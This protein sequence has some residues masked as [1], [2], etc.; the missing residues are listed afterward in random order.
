MVGCV[1][2]QLKPS[3]LYIFSCKMA[4]A[5][6]LDHFTAKNVEL[7]RLYLTQCI[8]FCFEQAFLNHSN[9]TFLEHLA[10]QR[11]ESICVALRIS[12]QISAQ[13]RYA[14]DQSQ[15]AISAYFTS[16]QILPFG[17]AEKYGR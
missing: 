17:F 16:E 11:A 5:F 10:L 15:K 9:K 4:T 3:G 12:V 14:A 13:V 2:S 1:L 8:R 6:G 7:L